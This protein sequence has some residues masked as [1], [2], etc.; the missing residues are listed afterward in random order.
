MLHTPRP[1]RTAL[2]LLCLPLCLGFAF[3]ALLGFFTAYRTDVSPAH[4]A[5]QT[6]SQTHLEPGALIQGSDQPT[7]EPREV[8]SQENGGSEGPLGLSTASV[9]AFASKAR[10]SSSCRA[11]LPKMTHY[12]RK[13]EKNCRVD[14]E[15]A[16]MDVY[17]MHKDFEDEYPACKTLWFAGT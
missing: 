13:I 2:K 1:K 7:I 6:L 11:V 15:K 10:L 16:T 4:T 3:L 5:I 8:I 9:R 14:Y 12:C 17:R